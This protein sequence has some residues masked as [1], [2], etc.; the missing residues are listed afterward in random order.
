MVNLWSIYGNFGDFGGEGGPRRAP[1]TAGGSP[2]RL[3]DDLG[4][5]F[6]GFWPPFGEP[7]GALRGPFGRQSL[8]PGAFMSFFVLFWGA[9]K[10]G[11]KKLPNVIRKGAF[12]EA[13]DMAQV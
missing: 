7:R 11:P 8:Q 12:L 10:K 2:R 13:V 1:L 6:D 9:S 5:I 3:R 4:T